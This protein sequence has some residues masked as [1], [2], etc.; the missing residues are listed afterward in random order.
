M[1]VSPEAFLHLLKEGKIILIFDGF[2]EMATQSNAA[3]TMKN[4][5]ELNRAFAGKAKILL[6]CRTHYFKDRVETEET[7]KVGAN[8]CV[9]PKILQY[10]FILPTIWPN[11]NEFVIWRLFSF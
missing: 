10:F 4:F 8:L 9:R 1:N 2:D 3:L 11:L 7:L 5:M 6:T